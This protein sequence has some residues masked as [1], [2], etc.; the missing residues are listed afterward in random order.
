MEQKGCKQRMPI[1][2]LPNDDAAAV[3]ASVENIGQVAES[4]RLG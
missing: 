4:N 1:R 3:A 2:C